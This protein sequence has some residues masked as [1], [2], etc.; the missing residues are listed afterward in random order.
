MKLCIS[1][2]DLLYFRHLNYPTKQAWFLISI[3]HFWVA[4]EISRGAIS[5]GP[6]ILL[7][8]TYRRNPVLS[9]DCIQPYF[10]ILKQQTS[11]F[12]ICWNKT[13]GTSMHIKTHFCFWSLNTINNYWPLKI[14]GFMNCKPASTWMW[15]WVCTWWSLLIILYL[16]CNPCLG[17]SPSCG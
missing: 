4:Y 5:L 7:I 6:R 10:N 14:W 1:Y 9:N 17:N 3:F 12:T 2:N 8:F 16:F 11:V 15:V 13:S